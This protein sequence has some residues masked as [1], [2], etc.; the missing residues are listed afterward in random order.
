ML[1]AW[2][3]RGTYAGRSTFSAWLY[4]IAT[5]ACLT[6]LARR[7]RALLPFELVAATDTTATDGLARAE[8]RPDLPWLEPYP[9]HLLESATDEDA[10]PDAAAVS[11]ETIEL[12]YLAAIQHLPP[13]Q[14]AVLILRDA[15]GWSERETAALLDSSVAAVKAALTR[16]RST[17]RAQLPSHR[18]DW[19]ASAPDPAERAVLDRF[20]AAF[21]R[22]DAG[23]L[24]SLLCEDARQSMPPGLLWF[25]GRASIVTHHGRLLDG[26]MGEFRLV[27]V[28]ANRQPGTGRVPAAAGRSGISPF[29]SERL[30]HRRW[31][32]RRDHQL[33]PW[34]LQAVRP[35]DQAV[36]AT[37]G[38]HLSTREA[39]AA[40]AGG[41]AP[42]DRP[43]PPV[44]CRR[45]AGRAGRRRVRRPRDRAHRRDSSPLLAGAVLFLTRLEP[46][47]LRTGGPGAAVLSVARRRS[48]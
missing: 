27:P 10:T 7:P 46:R 42:R 48:I 13:R 47:R 6:T 5:N 43:A 40:W 20:M 33:R 15:L 21:D 12:A 44:R 41:A 30:P 2:R 22:A 14:R 28:M 36:T 25:D 31:A 29:R 38:G 18:L 19:S 23:A 1:R 35:A 37:A 4:R 24:T 3:S 9:D 16:A 34:T 11:R 17:M 39:P 45:V 26:S 32:H 8:W